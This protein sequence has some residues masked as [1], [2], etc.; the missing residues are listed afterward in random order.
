GLLAAWRRHEIGS[1]S[2]V[3][4]AIGAALALGSQTPEIGKY[5]Y[6]A[7]YIPTSILGFFISRIILTIIFYLLFAPLG[8]L[9]KLTGKDLLNLKRR[10][11]ASEWTP[12]PGVRDRK[13]YYRQF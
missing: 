11:G 4:W 6:L 3:L 1:A 10:A 7:V 12:H 9:L 5:F 2:W 8:L 13:S